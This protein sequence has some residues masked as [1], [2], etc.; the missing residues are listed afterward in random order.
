MRIPAISE[1]RGVRPRVIFI[2]GI[3]SL[4]FS[5]FTPKMTPVRCGPAHKIIILLPLTLALS[6]HAGRGNTPSPAGHR[7]LHISTLPRALV[8]QEQDRRAE[9]RSAFRPIQGRATIHLCPS[10]AAIPFP[11]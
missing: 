11:A 3:L 5:L 10:I 4:Q 1:T 6:R 8:A 2:E 7:Y 9:K